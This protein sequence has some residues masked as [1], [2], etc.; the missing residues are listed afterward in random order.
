MRIIVVVVAVLACAVQGATAAE[1]AV[2]VAPAPVFVAPD[3]YPSRFLQQGIFFELGARYWYSSGKYS[4]DLF[5]QDPSAGLVSRLTYSGLT[6]NAGEFF[7][8]V[9]Q[10]N[11]YF[12][13]WIVGAGNTFG[14]ELVDEDFP[15]N[16]VPLSRT[17]SAQRDGG[18]GY[19]TLDLGYNV[20][21]G[22]IWQVGPFVG[23]NFLRET[24]NGTGCVQAANNPGICVL[25]PTGL[26][27]NGRVITQRADWTSIRVGVNADWNLT[28]QFRLSA[29]AAYLPYTKLEAQDT[30]L[31]RLLTSPELGTGSGVQL[32]AIASYALSDSFSIGVGGRYWFMQ[33][34]GRAIFGGNPANQE[35][36]TT[37]TERFGVFLQGTYTFGLPEIGRRSPW[38]SCC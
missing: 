3:P 31:L 35:P 18:L 25:D 14:G 23:V 6:N 22:P 12:L 17:T 26:A 4:K 32:E 16:T 2:P 8:S 37:K 27:V 10:V 5:N 30:H 20:L 29:N 13:K 28:N 33:A 9:K 11:G 24:L 34:G 7:G 1:I 21:G 15:P 36:L 38:L 19:A